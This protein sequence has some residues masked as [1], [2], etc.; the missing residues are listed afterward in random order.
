M[1]TDSSLSKS[2]AVRASHISSDRLGAGLVG[3]LVQNVACSGPAT[4]S[5]WV[6]NGDSAPAS[7]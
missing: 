5:V 7:V 1:I 2:L 6:Q 4:C 3:K